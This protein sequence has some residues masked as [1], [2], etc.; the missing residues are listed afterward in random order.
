[1]PQTD[2][3]K[4]TQTLLNEVKNGLTISQGSLKAKIEE[5]LNNRIIDATD[6]GVDVQGRGGL[7]PTRAPIV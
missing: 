6:T 3:D 7:R 1:M 5:I 4:E 2:A